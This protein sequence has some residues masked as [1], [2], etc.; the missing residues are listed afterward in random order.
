MSGKYESQIDLHKVDIYLKDICRIDCEHVFSR[1]LLRVHSMVFGQKL[2]RS[3]LLPDLC[4]GETLPNV[5]AERKWPVEMIK[6]IILVTVLVKT[7]SLRSLTDTPSRP[8]ALFSFRF[9]IRF[10]TFLQ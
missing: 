9:V 1:I 4:I 3:D 6:L 7:G 8:V 2:F 5:H 10:I